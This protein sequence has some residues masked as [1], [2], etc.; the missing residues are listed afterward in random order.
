ML[1]A[2]VRGPDPNVVR[3]C[4]RNVRQ[5]RGTSKRNHRIHADPQLPLHLPQLPTHRKDQIEK[6]QKGLD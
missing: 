5:M 4:N 1:F 6:L 2:M 3:T